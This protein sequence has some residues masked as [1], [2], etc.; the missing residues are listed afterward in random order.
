[1]APVSHVAANRHPDLSIRRCFAKLKDPRR[2]HGRLHHLQDIIVIAV[3]AIIHGADWQG[4]TFGRKREAWLSRFLTLTNGIPSHDTFE[5]VF[6]RL[7]PRA[8]QACFRDWVRA[9]SDALRIK[10]VAIDGKTF[11]GP[12]PPPSGRCIWS[13]PGPPPNGC[14]SAR[15]RWTRRR[16]DFRRRCAAARLLL[17]H[18]AGA[19]AGGPRALARRP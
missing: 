2:S 16:W 18:G 13:A 7:Q 5:R 12:G 3:C 15:W 4:E 10:H 17:C 8:F 9:V 6:D 11:A 1:M 14:R 19:A